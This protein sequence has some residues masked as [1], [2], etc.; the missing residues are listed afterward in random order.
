MIVASVHR[1]PPKGEAPRRWHWSLDL[2][3]V[4]RTRKHLCGAVATEAAA[5]RQARAA[6]AWWME[7]SCGP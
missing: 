6:W 4:E 3:P 7:K 5:K 2:V 1:D